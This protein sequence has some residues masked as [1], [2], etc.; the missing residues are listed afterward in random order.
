MK[1]KF[2]VDKIL[3][4]SS[5]GNDS[6]LLRKVRVHRYWYIFS[7]SNTRTHTHTHTQA[8]KI[9]NMEVTSVVVTPPRVLDMMM[10][11]EHGQERQQSR[12]HVIS[13]RTSSSSSITPADAL[14]ELRKLVHE[15][16]RRGAVIK[17]LDTRYVELSNKL[18]KIVRVVRAWTRMS[19]TSLIRIIRIS[20]ELK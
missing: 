17:R 20:L 13:T 6:S 7:L 2:K 18:Y 12:R 1:D 3:R 4:S 16:E 5:N 19:L 15:N 10:E 9:L 14:R 8:R 11:H